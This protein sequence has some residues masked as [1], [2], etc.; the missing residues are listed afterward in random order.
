M[1]MPELLPGVEG[2]LYIM[3]QFILNY[4]LQLLPELHWTI[5]LYTITSCRLR[6]PTEGVEV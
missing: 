4:C 5:S 1:E 6:V 3:W 2:H